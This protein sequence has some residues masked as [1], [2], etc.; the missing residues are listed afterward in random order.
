MSKMKPD[1]TLETVD[2]M[3]SATANASVYPPTPSVAAIVRLRIEE[4]SEQTERSPLFPG[5]APLRIALAVLA[6]IALLS[7]IAV[8]SYPTSRE[9]VADFFGLS[10]VRV[11]P[12]PSPTA[13]PPLAPSN[14]GRPASL[15]QAK[16]ELGFTVSLPTYPSDIGQPN[17][18]YL[19]TIGNAEVIA[20]VYE[21]DGL[22]FMVQQAGSNVFIEKS[23]EILEQAQVNGSRALWIADA[24]HI[25]QFYDEEGNLHIESRR[26]VE[27]NTL[28]WQRDGVTYR[29]EG[30]ISL[31]DAIKIAESLR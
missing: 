21:T 10:R 27:G 24:N 29:L 2:R 17:G 3:L 20:L 5:I 11:V 25:V 9:A 13:A 12:P 16:S 22:S 30:D 6:G 28:I 31:E 18:V 4:S 8:A 15:E 14:I 1:V 23:A 7:A 26:L 19:L